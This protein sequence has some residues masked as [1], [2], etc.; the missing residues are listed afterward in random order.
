[1]GEHVRV[2]TKLSKRANEWLDKRSK[3]TAIPKSTLIVLAIEQYMQQLET[4]ENMS[5]MT[6]IFSKLEQLESKM[7]KQ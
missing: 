4:V 6:E 5:T 3:K 2:N 7:E 1:M